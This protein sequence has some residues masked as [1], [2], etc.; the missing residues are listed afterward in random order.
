MYG[1]LFV[2]PARAFLQTKFFLPKKNSFPKRFLNRNLL[3]YKKN[4]PPI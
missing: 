1:L 3:L 2:S 4:N